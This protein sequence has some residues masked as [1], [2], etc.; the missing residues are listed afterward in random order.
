MSD[1]RN[2][3]TADLLNEVQ[4]RIKCASK[5]P[6]RVLFVGP[7][8][9]GKGTQ[10]QTFKE[11]HCLCHLATG[12]ML[13]AAVSAKTKVGL[14]AKA[15]MD[16][17]KLVSDEIV[18]NLIAENLG[19]NDCKRGFILDGFPRTVKQAEKLDDLLKARGEKLDSV[20]EFAVPDSILVERVTGRLIHKK[21]GRS[22]HTIFNP[23][24]VA[25][26]DDIT[27]EPLMHRGDDNAE[28]LKT[29]LKAYHNQTAP[30]LS[31]YKSQGILRPIDANTSFDSVY[32]QLIAATRVEDD[33]E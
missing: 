17:G 14:E 29:R 11:D 27:G 3:S 32:Q 9:S 19:R 10:S 25:G 16:A 26:K 31:Y 13:R 22:Y 30:V 8:G 33:Y 2:V 20:V 28:S 7:P 12:D 6:R 24:K 18:V 5:A 4:R 15:V 21:S 1:L 23:P